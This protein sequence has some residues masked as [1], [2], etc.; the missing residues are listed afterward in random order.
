VKL[1]IYGHYRDISR[2]P[3]YRVGSIMEIG[4]AE[5]NLISLHGNKRTVCKKACPNDKL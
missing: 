3:H 2:C 4:I 5:R 1:S